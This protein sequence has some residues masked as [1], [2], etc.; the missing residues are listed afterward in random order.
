MSKF[1][2]AIKAT[3]KG[4]F[5]LG[6]VPTEAQYAEWIDRI[7]EGIQEHQHTA[8]GGAGSGT[9]DAGPVI[10]LQHG[11][12]SQRPTDPAVGDVWVETDTARLYVCF[13][14]GT[15]TEV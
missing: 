5:N 4:Y 12:E 11:T 2:N 1:T 3:L 13:Q 14:A 15:W 9:G 8:T 10:N 6:D 7:Q